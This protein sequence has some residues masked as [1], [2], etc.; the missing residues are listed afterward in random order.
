MSQPN[1]RYKQRRTALLREEMEGRLQNP[2]GFDETLTPAEQEE[3]KHLA[4]LIARIYVPE[5]RPFP[6]VDIVFTGPVARIAT[7]WWKQGLRVV[8]EKARVAVVVE[9]GKAKNVE[10]DRG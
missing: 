3:I 7:Q 6:E 2:F 5:Q 1:R 8:P 9:N 4:A 10:V